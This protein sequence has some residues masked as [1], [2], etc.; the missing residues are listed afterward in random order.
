MTGVEF[1]NVINE[2]LESCK[3]TLVVKGKEYRRND[4]PLHN[5]DVGQQQSTTGE[6]REEVIYGMARK[7]WISIQDIRNDIKEGKL[8]TKAMLDEKFGDF[9]NYLLIEKAS[10]VDKINIYNEEQAHQEYW[11]GHKFLNVDKDV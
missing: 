2:Q 6:T 3:Q 9:I 4:N 7:H 8:P 10:I 11:S 5:F 1:D